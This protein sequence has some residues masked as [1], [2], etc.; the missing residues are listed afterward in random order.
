MH[1]HDRAVGTRD[2]RHRRRIMAKRRH[3]VDHYRAC[4]QRIAHDGGAA[5]VDAPR[6]AG[7]ARYNPRQPR[8]FGGEV[9]GLSARTRRF[10]TDVDNVRACRM[11]GA[12][13]GDGSLWF[14]M[15]TPIRKAV[16]GDV[17]DAHDGGAVRGDERKGRAGGG[18]G[19]TVDRLWIE[20]LAFGAAVRVANDAGD[21]GK[22]ERPTG[23]GF[24]V[25][26]D[27]AWQEIVA[28]HFD[29]DSNPVILAHASTQGRAKHQSGSSRSNVGAG[30]CQHD[31][32][33]ATPARYTARLASIGT[34]SPA[35]SVCQ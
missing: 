17:E 8:T 25:G 33:Y 11:H 26:A 10:G 34:S 28:S 21:A 30:V 2:Q 13:G 15:A 4:R 12:R 27:G 5:R 19:G 16:G 23:E 3:V 20:G 1:Q 29:A 35:S 31:A 22:F 7:E 18:K 24:P 14:G 6:Q 32:R 9:D